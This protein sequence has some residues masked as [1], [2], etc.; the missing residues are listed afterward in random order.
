[1]K[2]N[3]QYFKVLNKSKLLFPQMITDKMT[4]NTGLCENKGS[5]DDI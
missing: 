3:P 5:N 4:T 2:I 1:M